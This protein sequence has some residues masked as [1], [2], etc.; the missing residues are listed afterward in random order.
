MV[1]HGDE[2]PHN[3][4]YRALAEKEMWENY[5]KSLYNEHSKEKKAAGVVP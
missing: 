2:L 1:L 3:L 5:I 4:I